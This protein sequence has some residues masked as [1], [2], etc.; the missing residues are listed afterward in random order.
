MGPAARGNGLATL[1][2]VALV[3]GRRVE[4]T[5]DSGA[6]S[7]CPVAPVRSNPRNKRSARCSWLRAD[8]A[9]APDHK[10]DKEI[11]VA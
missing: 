6:F 5:R 4:A 2:A 7:C 3:R 1:I 11:S 8:A 9:E 10:A